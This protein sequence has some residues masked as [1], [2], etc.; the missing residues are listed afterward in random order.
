MTS[1][2][3]T[4]DAV[5]KADPQERL[6]AP[7]R[8]RAAAPFALILTACFLVHAA[9]L[10]LLFLMDFSSSGEPTKAE[11]IPVEIVAQM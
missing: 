9:L 8:P 3:E 1:G 7:A 2:R 6:T 10:A 5:F 4:P 11:E